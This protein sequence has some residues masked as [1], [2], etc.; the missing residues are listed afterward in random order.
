MSSETYFNQVASKWDTMRESFFSDTV[1]DV[2]YQIAGITPGCIAADIGCGTGFMTEGLL[3]KDI[4]VIAVDQSKAML[5]QIEKTFNSPNLICL[6]GESE[7]LPMD[8]NTVDFVF[9]NM[10]LHHVESPADAVCEMVR[11][12]KP[13]GKL[14]ITDL[15]E[16]PFV[17]LKTEHHDRWMGFRRDCMRDWFIEAGLNEVDIACVGLDCCAT[18]NCGSD[19]AKISIFA[20]SG[21]KP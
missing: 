10:Y 18:S 15:D 3:R 4:K 2:A 11:I 9:A 6:Q 19:A 16:H 1:R 17:F 7:A 13:G 20:A 8:D 14:V 12:L 5:E 21:K